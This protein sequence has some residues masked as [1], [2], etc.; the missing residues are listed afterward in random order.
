MLYVDYRGIEDTKLAFYTIKR[1][2]RAHLEGTPLHVGLRGLGAP[3]EN[4]KYWAELAWLGGHDEALAKI[5]A[6]GLDIGGTYRFKSL[7]LSPSITLGYAFG[8][9]DSNPND[10]R[11][12]EFRQTGLQSNERRWAGVA[13]FKYYGE[14]LDPELSNLHILTVGL[15]SSA[16]TNHHSRLS[17]SS[18]SVGRD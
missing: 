5:Q 1:N 14:G 3:T 7:P 9:G 8:S 4:F 6:R 12:T 16:S 15:G 13:D 18:L 2:D 10:R 17:L 11:N